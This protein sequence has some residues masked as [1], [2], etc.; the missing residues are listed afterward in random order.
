MH[1]GQPLSVAELLLGAQEVQSRSGQC[2]A[3][4]GGV[5][6]KSKNALISKY[7]TLNN[8][9]LEID[10]D[11]YC[12]GYNI[13]IAFIRGFDNC[14]TDIKEEFSRQTFLYSCKTCW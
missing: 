6:C 4:Y 14:L 7:E 13:Q 1:W 9:T 11:L 3:E 8:I 5:L 10:S 2:A 12:G